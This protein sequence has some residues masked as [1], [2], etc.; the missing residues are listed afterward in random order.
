MSEDNT[1]QTIA[2]NPI[3]QEENEDDLDLS[4][5]PMDELQDDFDEDEED[6]DDDDDLYEKFQRII[7]DEEEFIK[8]KF[9]RDNSIKLINSLN[10]ETNEEELDQ[11]PIEELDQDERLRLLLENLDDEQMA[12]YSTYRRSTINKNNLRKIINSILNQSVSHSV[13]IAISGISKIFI[14]EIIEKAK[15]IK[16]RYDRANY[17]IKLSEKKELNEL[18]KHEL[19][20]LETCKDSD[21]IPKIQEKI[22]TINKELKRYNL[23]NINTNGPLLPEHIREA[24]RLYKAENNTPSHQW[25]LQGEGDGL[26]FR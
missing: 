7:D 22:N 5:V 18:L 19:T 3:V 26:M 20:N 23:L 24:W 9:L 4:D 12:R 11:E 17:L 10:E 15:D 16:I 14:G 8:R 1:S 13:A 6:D 21:E 2:Q 25:A